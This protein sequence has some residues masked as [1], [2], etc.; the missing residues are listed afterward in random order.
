MTSFQFPAT[1]VNVLGTMLCAL[2]VTSCGGNSLPESIEK[3][4]IEPPPLVISAPINNIKQAMFR[5][6]DA[7]FEHISGVVSIKVT[8]VIEDPSAKVESI[9]LYWANS[10]GSTQGE[11][12]LKTNFSHLYNID[13]PLGTA[14]PES[15]KAL[16]LYTVNEVGH[17][18]KGTLI[19]FHDFTGNTNLS[20]LGGNES[21]SWEYGAD[22]P[23]IAIN[24]SNAQGGL[25]TFDNGLVSVINMGN[26]KDA[27]WESHTGAMLPNEA[28]DNAFPPY[29]F[30]CDEQ[31]THTPGTISDEIGVWTYSTLND[32]MFYGTIV[33]DSFV[34]YLG[35][36]PLKNKMR[37]RVH[38]GNQFESAAYWDGAYANFG[39]AYGLSYSMASL[40]VIAH[41]I[42]H[43]VLS[44]ISPLNPYE[45]E[46]STDAKTIHE[47]FGDISGVIAKYEFTGETHWIHGEESHGFTRQ[48]N[49]IQT[50]NSAIASF[51][52]YEEAGDNFYLRIGMMTYPFYL[53]SNQ[54]GVEKAYAVYVAAAKNCWNSLTTLTLAAQ[55]I[56]QYAG[57]AGLSEEEVTSAF[58]S[59]KI[60][61]FDEGVLSHFT[62]EKFKLSVNFNDDSRTTNQISQWHWD[63]GDGQTSIE[64]NPTHTFSEAGAYPVKLT[65]KDQ[66]NDQD[67][68]ERLIDVTDQYC[69]M[70]P[71]L[72][73][74]QMMTVTIDGN[75][76]NYQPTEW[77][78]TQ[79]PIAL[80]DP[81]KVVVD[82]QGNNDISQRSITWKVWID[83]NGN[84]LYGDEDNE[85]IISEFVTRG[86]PY[87]LNTQLDL[88]SLPN[89]GSPK[90]MRIIG[91]YAVITPCYSN[92]GEGLD[93]RVSW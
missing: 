62:A 37:L 61:L 24:R 83:L 6:Q 13:I 20:G 53:L 25:C 4:P 19:P 22:R 51:F 3:P 17:S 92:V 87:N 65:V 32:A 41:E 88:S 72:G 39:D 48:L 90:Y 2:M 76:I 16:M 52:D 86:L 26:T 78:Y 77:D 5:D 64:E 63:F 74:N 57:I 10:D 89:D 56:K 81:S 28:N 30:L 31:P 80:T 49:K 45:Q 36:P 91:D 42:G 69:P 15:A 50:E 27:A 23:N 43:G 29:S 54:W 75:Q 68:F 55:C 35:E 59:V 38:Y 18:A 40:D 67:T 7:S 93:V 11:A 73:D 46:L 60:K 12:W 33:Y 71:S 1:K 58:K 79:T 34:K 84:G 47:A 9:W 8:D 14:I 70:H 44:R 66:S 82:I 21:E 85:L